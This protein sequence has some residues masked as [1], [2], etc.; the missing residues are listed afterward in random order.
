[1]DK[2]SCKKCGEE[3]LLSHFY[4][5]PKA[6]DGRDSSCKDCRKEAV[7]KN[8]EKNADYYRAYDAKRFKEDPRVRARH[9][10]YQATE[11]GQESM[12]RAKEKWA[13]ENPD[14]LRAA[15]KRWADANPEKKRAHTMVGNAVRDGRLSKPE[16]C[17]ECGA[18]GLIHGHHEDY[19]KPLDVDW[20]CPKC[21]A[22]RHN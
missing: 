7:R 5:H 12:R 13:R 19:S 6:A 16:K 17:E 11:A 15:K 10:R 3:K 9:K 14:E 4:K 18:G 1:M 21:H 22:K 2:K 20:L 8:R